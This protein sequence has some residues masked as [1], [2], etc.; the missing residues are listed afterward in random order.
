MT[1]V[2]YS[3]LGFCDFGYEAKVLGWESGEIVRI[4]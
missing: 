2:G 1:K 3:Y 4:F